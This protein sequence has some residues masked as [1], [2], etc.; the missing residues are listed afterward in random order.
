MFDFD[1]FQVFTFDCYGTL[2]DWEAGILAALRPLLTDQ[3]IR[4]DDDHI[5]ELYG[6]FESAAQRGP[7]VNYKSI[8]R[9]A[10]QDFAVHFGFALAEPERDSLVDSLRAWPPFPDTVE[11]LRALKAKYRLVI[12]SNID[13]DLFQHSARLLQTPFDDVITAQQVGAYKPSLRNFEAMLQRVSVAREQILHVAQSLYHDIGP[14]KAMGLA[15]V[16]V[17]RRH[18]RPGSGATPPAS[19]TPDLEVSDLRTLVARIGL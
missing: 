2:I 11:A 9:Q 4:L 8:L 5:L 12:V 18:G 14:A 10:A 1:Q 3:G 15:T 19:A 17:N 13:D 7:Y 16:W 6:R